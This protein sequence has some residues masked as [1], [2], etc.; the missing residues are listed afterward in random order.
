MYAES[1]IYEDKNETV[2]QPEAKRAPQV[3]E[4]LDVLE[5]TVEAHRAICAE[6][7]QRLSGVLRNEPEATE[8]GSS[9]D[10]RTVVGLAQRMND[11]SN[12]LHTISN[13][14]NSMLRRLEL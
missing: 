6:M 12:Q 7:E 1:R 11:I 9:K 4:A 5:K 8:A 3:A 13:S 10:N 14:Y 2:N